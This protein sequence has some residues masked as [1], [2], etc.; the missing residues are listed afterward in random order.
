[1]IISLTEETSAESNSARKVV[2]RL[3]EWA[4]VRI[5]GDRLWDLK[6][7]DGRFS[8]RVLIATAFFAAIF[9]SRYNNFLI[10]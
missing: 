1:M 4:D 2:Q 6:V 8:K 10:L 9:N 5:D 3:L 7:N